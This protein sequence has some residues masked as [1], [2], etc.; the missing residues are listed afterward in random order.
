MV[1]NE[2]T[3]KTVPILVNFLSCSAQ[4]NPRSIGKHKQNHRRSMEAL[5]GL[6]DARLVLSIRRTMETA[7]NANC[8][9]RDGELAERM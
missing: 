7:Q 3:L 8:A 9:T 2:R 4:H 1:H 5:A 6:P